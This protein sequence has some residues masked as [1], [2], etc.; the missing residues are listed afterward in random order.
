MKRSYL[1]F[2]VAMFHATPLL[3]GGYNPA[4]LKD[5][6]RTYRPPTTSKMQGSTVTA[7]GRIKEAVNGNPLFTKANLRIDCILRPGSA[8]LSIPNFSKFSAN[9]TPVTVIDSWLQTIYEAGRENKIGKLNLFLSDS[10]HSESGIMLS[11]EPQNGKSGVFSD[12]A[13]VNIGTTPSEL[14]T[15]VSSDSTAS[16]EIMENAPSVSNEIRTQNT[17]PATPPA[18]NSGTQNTVLNTELPPPPPMK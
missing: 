3:A 7:C 9:A 4:V 14:E 8:V 18:Y 15:T 13:K 16:P 12:W 17:L 6:S 2:M 10:I 5:I 11:T 1:I